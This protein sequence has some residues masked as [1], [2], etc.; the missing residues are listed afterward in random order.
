MRQ[1]TNN[2]SPLVSDLIDVDTLEPSIKLCICY[3]TPNNFL[4]RPFYDQARALLQLP[5]AVDLVEVHRELVAHG[6]GLIVFDAY[7]PWSVTKLFWDLTPERKRQ[8]VAD[9]EIGSIHNRG[10]AVDVS[11]YSL[12]DST[13]LEMPSEYDEMSERAVPSYQGGATE[14]RQNRDRL[15]SSMERH[16]FAVHPLEWWHF[17]HVTWPEY[18]IEDRAFSVIPRR[19]TEDLSRLSI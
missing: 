4:G 6:H 11:I 19:R 13:E 17:D 15:R 10:C 18:P 16:H 9:P 8:F 3:A 12:A 14:Q 7:R 1:S 5:V 2:R